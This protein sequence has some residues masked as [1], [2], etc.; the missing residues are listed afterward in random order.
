MIVR[1]RDKKDTGHPLRSGRINGLKL[2]AL[3]VLIRPDLL[4]VCGELASCFSN[5]LY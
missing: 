5:I 2:R 4:P 3:C 1:K